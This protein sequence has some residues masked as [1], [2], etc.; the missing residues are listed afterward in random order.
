MEED[1]EGIES[2][3][4]IV[5]KRRL[6]MHSHVASVFWWEFEVGVLK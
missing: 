4:S 2:A 5:S 1:W 3:R 6:G